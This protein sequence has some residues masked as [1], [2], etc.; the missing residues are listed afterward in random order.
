MKCLWECYC[1]YLVRE[2][3]ESST[4]GLGEQA[5]PGSH[6]QKDHLVPLER[7]EAIYNTK[8]YTPRPYSMCK[9]R[10]KT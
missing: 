5:R 4:D 7:Q 8:S 1:E 2:L 10:G 3:R 9:R 6:G